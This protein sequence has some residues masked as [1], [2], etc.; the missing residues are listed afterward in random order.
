MTR[1]KRTKSEMTAYRVSPDTVKKMDS[2]SNA[3]STTRTKVFEAM[4]DA[5][6]LMSIGEAENL[7]DEVDF[8]NHFKSTRKLA[9]NLKVKVRLQMEKV[10][11]INL[12]RGRPKKE[13]L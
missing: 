1:H 9:E 2:I 11:D 10:E 8:L 7:I 13:K 4:V 5:V 3:T 12:K 6:Y